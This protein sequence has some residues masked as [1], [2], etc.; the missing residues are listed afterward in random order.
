MMKYERY[1]V[2]ACDGSLISCHRTP[3]GAQRAARAE[4][5]ALG[6]HDDG[7]YCGSDGWPVIVDTV[8]D[9]RIDY[10]VFEVSS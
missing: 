3:R 6:L 2:R 5:R 1:E 7:T 4:A 10:T 9:A 8:G